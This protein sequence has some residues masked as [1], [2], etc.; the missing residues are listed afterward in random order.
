M[1]LKSVTCFAVLRRIFLLAA[2]SWL[3]LFTLSA[4]SPTAATSAEQDPPLEGKGSHSASNAVAEGRVLDPQG[5]SISDAEVRLLQGNLVVAGTNTD[6]AGNFRLVGHSGRYTLQISKDGFANVTKVMD[7]PA[8]GLELADILLP[9]AIAKTTVNVTE[10]AEYL[11]IATSSA[12]KTLTPLSDVPQSISV[13]TSAQIKDQMMLSIADAVNYVPGVTAIQ[14]ENNRDQ[15]VIRGNST[16]ADFFINGVRDDVQYYRDLYDVERIEI[17]KGPNALIFGRGGAGGIVNRVTKLAGGFPIRELTLDGGSFGAKRVAMDLNQ[18]LRKKFAF[19]LNGVYENSGTFRDYVTLERWGIAPTMTFTPDAKSSATVSYERFNDSRG[20]DRGI[21]SFQNS[22][23]DVP[24]NTFFGNPDYN[25][26][27]AQLD[28]GAATYERQLGGL[29]LR[30]RFS[31]G[32][33]NRFYQNFVPGAVTPDGAMDS[34]SAYNNATQRRNL[35]NQTDLIHAAQTGNIKHTLLGG[36]EFG[37]QLTNNFRNTGYFSNSTTTVLAPISDPVI[38]VPVTFRQSTTDANNH[39]TANLA[40]IYAQDQVELSKYLQLLGGLRFDYFG[41]KYHDNRAGTNL[42][43]ID[44]LLSPRAGVVFKPVAPVSIYGSYGV[45]YL[46]GSGDQFS[47]LTIIT[48][49]MKP[50]TFSNYEVGLKWA[51]ARRIAITSALYRLDRTNTRSIDPN[52]STRIVQTGSQRTN[53]FEIG[54]TGNLT[55]NWMISGGYA[56]QNAFVSSAT[57][58]A[59]VAA[60]VAQAPHNTFSLWNNY[61]VVNRLGAGFGILNR[62]NMFAA[63]DNTVVLPGYTRFDTAVYYS[64]TERARLQVNVQNLF[65][66]RYYV[67]ADNNTN[68]SPGSPRAIVTAFVVRF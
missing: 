13:V 61:K 51:V 45:S 48:Q 9:V 52:D 30:D 21:P 62:S 59:R 37:R 55:R 27:R 54:A 42:Q 41:L 68:I 6:P 19:R 56:H 20:S 1:I 7:I 18:P 35:F 46:P 26:V 40:A 5:L 38:H 4:Q 24:I 66:R 29:T 60:Q 36:I 31:A 16:S 33:Y 3:S 15:L 22:P 63:I 43:R 28:L 11:V 44:H 10:S 49:Q 34:L 17:L 39:V 25:N 8:N 57:A 65:N 58:A 23:V 64:V 50:E 14:G 2:L 12:T 53:G 47:S 32:N 67:N